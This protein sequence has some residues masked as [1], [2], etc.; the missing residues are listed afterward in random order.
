M[1]VSG[2]LRGVFSSGRPHPFFKRDRISFQL[3]SSRQIKMGDIREVQQS[4]DTLL[5]K[6][7]WIV[8]GFEV[9]IV[10]L[11]RIF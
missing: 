7:G 2:V 10:D 5:E 4:T 8:C 9:V 6:A 11:P 3:F 1:R